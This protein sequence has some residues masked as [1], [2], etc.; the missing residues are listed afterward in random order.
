[1]KD[2]Y[3]PTDHSVGFFSPIASVANA[4][5]EIALAMSLT[6]DYDLSPRSDKWRT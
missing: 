1:M 3:K 5:I 6:G 4:L 2:L